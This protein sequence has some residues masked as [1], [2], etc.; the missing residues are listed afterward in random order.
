MFFTCRLGFL[1]AL[2]TFQPQIGGA[3]FLPHKYIQQFTLQH[4]IG[5]AAFLPHKYI[6]QFTLQSQVGG[7]AFLP[8]KN[9]RQECRTSYRKPCL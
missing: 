8:H 3:A 7:A 2:I 4:K 9:I 6:Q 1:L 5:G